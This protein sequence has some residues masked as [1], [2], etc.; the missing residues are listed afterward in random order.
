MSRCTICN[1]LL[2]DEQAT[3]IHAKTHLEIGLCDECL[4]AVNSCLPKPA[5]GKKHKNEPAWLD[6]LTPDVD[7]EY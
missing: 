7:W 2:T 4:D 5:L 3:R 1:M 6:T